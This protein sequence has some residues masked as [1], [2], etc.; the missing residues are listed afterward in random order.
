MSEFYKEWLQR[1]ADLDA[2]PYGDGQGD[3]REDE[4][5]QHQEPAANADVE[6]RVL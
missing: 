2:H 5:Q 1:D 3:Q 4:G 6:V